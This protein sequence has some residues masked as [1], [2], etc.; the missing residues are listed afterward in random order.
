[1]N[2]QYAP[3][4]HPDLKPPVGQTGVLLW[5]R[6]NLF[7]SP[8]NVALTIVTALVPKIFGSGRRN[9]SV[10]VPRILSRPL[11]SLPSCTPRTKRTC[12]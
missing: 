12:S 9:T 7:S 8:F 5:L 1:M 3:G 4:E 10:P 6:K 11:V 2:Q